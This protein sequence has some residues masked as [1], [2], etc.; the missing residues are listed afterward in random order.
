MLV[1]GCLVNLRKLKKKKNMICFLT[2]N[3]ALHSAV[4]INQ[5]FNQSMSDAKG[6]Q[7]SIC[8]LDGL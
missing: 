1:G 7:K 6:F 5:L 8:S 4:H 3:S 2:G